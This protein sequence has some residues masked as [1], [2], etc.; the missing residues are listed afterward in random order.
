MLERRVHVQPQLRPG[1]QHQLGTQQ[2]GVGAHRGDVPGHGTEEDT[3]LP[4]GP[5]RRFRAVVLEPRVG[6]P[7]CV[8]QCHPQLRAMEDI[9]ARSGELGV[10]DPA[11]GS[12]QIQFARA[13][14]GVKAGGVPVLDLA[15]EQPADSLQPRVGVALHP[16][17]T[18]VGNPVRAV[19]IEEAPRA[20][21]AEPTLRQGTA[22]VHR[23]RAA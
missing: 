8:G 12:H 6:V 14:D 11:S 17:A 10:A 9:G 1:L 22:H 4:T 21:E 2:R 13:N 7:R 19:V 23:T 15:G 16:H 3:H 5:D 18:G 20:D